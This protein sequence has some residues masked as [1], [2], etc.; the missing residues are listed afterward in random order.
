MKPKRIVTA[1]QR[2]AEIVIAALF[3]ITAATSIP[4]AFL[5]DPILNAPDYLAGAFPN[6]GAVALGALLWSINNI[7][8]VFIAVFALPLLNPFTLRRWPCSQHLRIYPA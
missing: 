1:T 7:G 4:A 2:R 5:L 8:I 6:R 3:L